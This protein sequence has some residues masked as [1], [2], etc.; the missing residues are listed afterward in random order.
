ME[1]PVCGSKEVGR[2]GAGTF[3]CW[4]CFVEY[5]AAGRK[6]FTL[7]EDGG[8]LAYVGGR[9]YPEAEGERHGK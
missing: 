2:I 8:T 9:P 7:T 5:Q 4:R 6:V 1:C 3:F